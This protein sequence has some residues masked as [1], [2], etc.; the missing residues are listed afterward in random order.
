MAPEQVECQPV[1][2]EAAD[3]YAFGV[4][5][6][7][8]LT[9]RLPFEGPSPAAVML[10]RLKHPAPAPSS[11]RPE[12]GRTLDEFV[13]TCLSRDPR[14]RYAD[15]GTALAA[16]ELAVR[17]A[18][19]P[20]RR[21]RRPLILAGVGLGSLACL[22]TFTLLRPAG[23]AES[24]G[25]TSVSAHPLE[26]QPEEVPVNVPQPPP[27][28]DGPQPQTAGAKRGTELPAIT[29]VEPEASSANEKPAMGAAG[30]SALGQG[31]RGA[32]VI[33]S[34]KRIEKVALPASAP[35]L[36]GSQESAVGAALR[37][38]PEERAAPRRAPGIPGAPPRLR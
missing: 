24:L 18:V 12:I 13:L 21:R 17:D 22:G 14:R 19:L 30:S 35:G 16:F 36:V 29:S 5:L 7:E 34:A 11:V 26:P 33:A 31:P 37:P 9:G 25:E 10:K 4:V 28:R 38:A 2:G 3:I 8:M 27:A 20:P 23:E 15:A 1:L 32:K 6:F